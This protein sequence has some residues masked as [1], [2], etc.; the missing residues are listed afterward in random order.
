MLNTGNSNLAGFFARASDFEGAG[1]TSQ[2]TNRFRLDFPPYNVPANGPHAIIETEA[3]AAIASSARIPRSSGYGGGAGV[4]VIDDL[5]YPFVGNGFTA[6]T[7]GRLVP[8]FVTANR[9]PVQM[10]AGRRRSCGCGSVMERRIRIPLAIRL[11]VIG[12]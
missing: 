3:S 11:R 1:T 7:D 5:S 6:S 9:D 12:N 2:L 8:E 4:E 10:L